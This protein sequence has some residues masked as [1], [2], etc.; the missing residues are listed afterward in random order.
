M[1]PIPV[2]LL[3]FCHATVTRT[4]SLCAVSAVVHTELH[5]FQWGE[6]RSN[7]RRKYAAAL[8][9]DADLLY[10]RR[11][12]QYPPLRA[13]TRGVSSLLPP[14]SG[15]LIKTGVPLTI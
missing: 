7:I 6:L 5:L 8:K 13:N 12:P 10:G 15:R 11:Y 3:Q 2:I 14:A 9:A 4:M 1:S